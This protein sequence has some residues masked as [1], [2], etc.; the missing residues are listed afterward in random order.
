ML[1]AVGIAYR[2][3]AAFAVQQRIKTAISESEFKEFLDDNAPELTDEERRVV[4]KALERDSRTPNGLE[5][6]LQGF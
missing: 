5:D 4:A 3:A 2:R 6:V 1:T